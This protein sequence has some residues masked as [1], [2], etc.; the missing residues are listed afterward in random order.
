MAEANIDVAATAATPVKNVRRFVA[1]P[2]VIPKIPVVTTGTLTGR[3]P[4][5]A[6]DPHHLLDSDHFLRFMAFK[7]HAQLNLPQ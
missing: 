4:P 1:S 5:R 7:Y 3:M 2:E 6:L